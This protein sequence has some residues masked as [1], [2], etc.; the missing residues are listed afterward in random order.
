MTLHAWDVARAIGGDEQLDPELADDVYE[1]MVPMAPFIGTIGM[2]G[3]GP[4]GQV[5]E[6]APAQVRL[7]DLSG[8]RG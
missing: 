4:S 8:R 3:S 2:F 5:D 7:L 1:S 6:S